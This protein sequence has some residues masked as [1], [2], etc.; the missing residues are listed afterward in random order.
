MTAPAAFPDDG[1]A[2]ARTRGDDGGAPPAGPDGPGPCANHAEE[3]FTSG[4][5]SW[6]Y[7]AGLPTKILSIEVR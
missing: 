1:V 7:A 6:R 4:D 2:W 3:G 5:S